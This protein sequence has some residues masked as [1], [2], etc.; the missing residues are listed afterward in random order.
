VQVFTAHRDGRITARAVG[1]AWQQVGYGTWTRARV[2]VCVVERPA[3][4][5]PPADTARAE[6]VLYDDTLSGFASLAARHARLAQ[7]RASGLPFYFFDGPTDPQY[8]EL[9]DTILAGGWNGAPYFYRITIPTLGALE[10]RSVYAQVHRAP[11]GAFHPAGSTLVVDYW[12]RISYPTPPYWV[13]GLMLLHNYDRTQVGINNS[14]GALGWANA[15][16]Q[17][18]QRDIFMHQEDGAAD[19]PRRFRRWADVADGQ[20]HRH[21][22]VYRAS[23]GTGTARDGVLRYFVDGEKLLDAS[24]EGL[25]SGWMRDRRNGV[26]AASTNPYPGNVGDKYSSVTGD[27][28]LLGLSDDPVIGL[29]WPGII[30]SLTAGPGGTLDLGRIRLSVRR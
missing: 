24:A 19:A 23:S 25:A 30:S 5:T 14:S 20:W 12:L 11:A 1:C 7:L 26:S 27:E 9:A 10:Q 17:S 22:V 18:N 21:T 15:L 8:R 13:K 29:I 28:A 16:P 4:P 2:S 6:T 3:T